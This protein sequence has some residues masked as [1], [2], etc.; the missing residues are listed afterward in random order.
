VVIAK[1][2]YTDPTGPDRTVPDNVRG[3]CLV[4]SGP[5]GS[6]RVRV[7]EFSY[8]HA[9]V[10]KLLIRQVLTKPMVAVTPPTYAVVILTVGRTLLRR[11]L[12]ARIN[13]ESTRFA[14]TL[15]VSLCHTASQ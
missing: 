2:P 1:F 5:V 12:C 15:N 14:F 10:Q 3:L 9:T 11:P 13:E 4:G 7:G 6:G 8:Y